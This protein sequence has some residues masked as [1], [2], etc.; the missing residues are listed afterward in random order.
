MCDLR[1]DLIHNFEMIYPRGCQFGN[2]F[3]DICANEPYLHHPTTSCCCTQFNFN[4]LIQF[5]NCNSR[6]CI[7]PIENLM[8]TNYT[9]ALLSIELVPPNILDIESTPSSV[10]VRENQ[11]I[12]MTCRADGFPTPKIIWRRYEI[13]WFFPS[14][15]FAFHCFY[16]VQRKYCVMNGIKYFLIDTGQTSPHSDVLRWNR[17]KKTVFPLK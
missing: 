9:F 10:A 11:N 12:N 3:T 1:S 16:F 7:C 15:S 5:G 17:K 6:I 14:S 8:S 4:P 13:N 2:K